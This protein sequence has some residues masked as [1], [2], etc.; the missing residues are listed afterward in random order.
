MI[1]FCLNTHTLEV[2]SFQRGVC[3]FSTSFIYE[4]MK[5]MRKNPSSLILIYVHRRD[6][7]ATLDVC[8]LTCALIRG[9]TKNRVNL[10]GALPKT[11]SL[12]LILSQTCDCAP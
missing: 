9:Q 10:G 5:E 6:V 12:G 4:I 1:L 2:C 11:I 8:D 3:H 7:R